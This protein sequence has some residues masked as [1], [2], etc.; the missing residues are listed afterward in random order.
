MFCVIQKAFGGPGER[1]YTVGELVNA[2]EWRLRDQL[3]AG[4]YMRPATEREI[5]SAEEVD[6]PDVP[7]RKTA[8]GKKR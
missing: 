1:Q 5:S 7:V 3:V 2:S 8:K 4:R 6:V